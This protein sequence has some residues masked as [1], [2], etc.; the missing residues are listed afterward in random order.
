MARAMV[1]R[2]FT[3]TKVKTL[4]VDTVN[5]TTVESVIDLV[6]MYKTDEKALKVIN[7]LNDNDNLKAVDCEIVG[8]ATERRGMTETEFYNNSVEIKPYK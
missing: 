3:T 7:T 2:T 5:K 6:G 4:F 8:H 1:T